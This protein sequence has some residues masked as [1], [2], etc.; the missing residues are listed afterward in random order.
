MRFKKLLAALLVVS[1]L[2]TT[3]VTSVFAATD[4]TYTGALS[5]DGSDDY[6]KL[7]GDGADTKVM[8]KTKSQSSGDFTSEATE[9]FRVT[10]P[11]TINFEQELDGSI[12]SKS[13]EITNE[14]SFAVEVYSVKI[15]EN[16]ESGWKVVAYDQSIRSE[17]AGTKKIGLELAATYNTINEED[18][19]VEE[20]QASVQTEGSETTEENLDWK[21]AAQT[22]VY[23]T[24]GTLTETV[25]G[26]LAFVV[27]AY[28]PTSKEVVS[29][30]QIATVTFVIKKVADAE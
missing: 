23:D 1:L 2:P 11:T 10:V 8:F 4:G 13:Y 16:A 28:A 6:T 25:P 3:A 27:S 21:I 7:S 5:G 26:T 15:A 14:S 19:S 18:G 22:K 30:V 17:A 12:P 9:I 20:K 29:S 24:E